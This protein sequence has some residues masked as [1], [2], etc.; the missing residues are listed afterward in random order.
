MFDQN[1]VVGVLLLC[2]RNPPGPPLDRLALFGGER[3]LGTAYVGIVHRS[4]D[5]IIGRHTCGLRGSFQIRQFS[6][7]RLLPRVL[8][9]QFRQLQPA[10]DL[11]KSGVF[12]VHTPLGTASFIGRLRQQLPQHPAPHGSG[13]VDLDD[14]V[15]RTGDVV[16]AVSSATVL[17]NIE[18]RPVDEVFRIHHHVVG[19]SGRL[20]LVDLLVELLGRDT[21]SDASSRFG[22]E[23]SQQRVA[24][25]HP[26]FAC[27]G[28]AWLVQGARSAAIQELLGLVVEVFLVEI[29]LDLALRRH[30]RLSFFDIIPRH[31]LLDGRRHVDV[32]VE[33]VVI[34]VVGPEIAQVDR[35]LVVTLRVPPSGF[36][37]GH[38]V[39]AGRKTTHGIPR[40]KTG[41]LPV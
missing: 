18:A 22:R 14:L 41:P 32:D 19:V 2:R 13:S 9:T 10:G 16:L 23:T 40:L 12:R 35:H 26:L 27:A 33:F 39:W 17:V 4:R 34:V 24:L 28:G 31:R 11:D 36:L 7:G 3:S 8:S 5:G 30:G 20:V 15:F 1:L 38:G 29:L 21:F 6:L 25:H 37:C